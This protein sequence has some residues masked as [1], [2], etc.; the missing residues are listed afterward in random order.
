MLLVSAVVYVNETQKNT[1][2]SRVEGSFGIL[3]VKQAAANTVLCALVNASNGGNESVL[4]ANLD[5]LASV[6]D[7]HSYDAILDLQF[8][9]LNNSVFREGVLLRWNESG[10]GASSAYVD[11]ALNTSGTLSSCF[12][13]FSVNL[14]STLTVAGS[15][16]LVNSSLVEVGLQCGL[17]NEGKPA[18]AESFGVSYCLGGSGSWLQAASANVTSSGD[19]LHLVSFAA[20]VS[21]QVDPLLVSVHAVDARGV[22]VWANATCVL[23]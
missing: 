20:P 6:L 3:A 1:P 4:A 13:E 17:W 23:S 9:P 15:Y 8:T 22:S 10:S 16:H 11:F 19:G 12:S 7:S 21:G 18:L 2:V 14:N 5:V